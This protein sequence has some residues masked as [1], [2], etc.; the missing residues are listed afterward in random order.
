MNKHNDPWYEYLFK[1]ILVVPLIMLAWFMIKTIFF[2]PAYEQGIDTTEDYQ[3]SDECR[4]YYVPYG[5]Y[6][7]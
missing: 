7:C 1:V 3:Q 2:D 4:S 5:P 6:G